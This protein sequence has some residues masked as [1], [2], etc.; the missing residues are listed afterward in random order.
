[1]PLPRFARSGRV[2]S[3]LAA[4]AFILLGVLPL[5]PVASADDGLSMTAHALLQGHARAGSWFAIAVDVQNAGPTVTGELRIAG[6]PDSRTRFGTP[7]EL[8]TGSRKEYLNDLRQVVG[9]N[10][11]DPG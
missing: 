4:T 11:Q 2:M 7:V 1:M 6:G 9:V 3:A 10:F 8:A 5:A